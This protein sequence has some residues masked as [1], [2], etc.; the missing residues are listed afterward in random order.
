MIAAVRVVPVVLDFVS[1]DEDVFSIL[2]SPGVDAGADHLDFGRIAV[3]LVA[4]APARVIRH[5][6]GAVELLVQVS[7]LRRMIV[8]L[9]RCR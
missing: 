2:P 8:A 6:P 1:G 9:G 4:A 3:R 5:I 7:V